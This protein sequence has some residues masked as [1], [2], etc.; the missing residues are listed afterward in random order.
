MTAILFVLFAIFQL[1]SADFEAWYKR[2]SRHMTMYM[3]SKE[4]SSRAYAENV[5]FITDFNSGNHSYTLSTE[6]RWVG[7]PRA[8][9]PSIFR[10]REAVRRSDRRG[11][12]G[13]SNYVSS[14]S[15]PANITLK[16]APDA[17]DWRSYMSPVRDQGSCGGC[18]TFGSVGALEGRLNMQ[19]NVKLDLSEQQAIDCSK[20]YGNHGCNGGLGENVYEYLIHGGLSYENDY[21]FIGTDQQCKNSVKHAYLKSYTCGLGNMK[22]HIAVGPVDIA[23]DVEGSFMY[24]SSG[25]YDGSGDSCGNDYFKDNHEMVAVG[26]GIH[27]GKTYY[28]IRNSWGS[29]WGINGYVYVYEN[30]CGVETD[31]EVPLS[32]SLA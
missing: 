5:K 10:K 16:A 9:L 8:K 7:F 19:Y 21:P 14:K 32:Y 2:Y 20:G 1:A 26:Y 6:G 17:I 15:K 30:V 29:S 25:Y 31:P 11:M 13:C 4:E 3:I 12:F 28:I 22:E 27:D 18:Y 24:Y 23:M